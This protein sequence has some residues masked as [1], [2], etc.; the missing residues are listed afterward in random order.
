MLQLYEFYTF[1]AHYELFEAI[2]QAPSRQKYGEG[3]H[4]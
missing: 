1:Q 3:N 4:L 2:G